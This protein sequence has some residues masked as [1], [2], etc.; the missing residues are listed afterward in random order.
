MTTPR[1]IVYATA[2]L[3]PH[4]QDARTLSI[5]L[6]DIQGF[7]EAVSNLEERKLDVMLRSPGGSAEAA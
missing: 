1:L 7:M 2:W 3:E 4:D 6:G 5:H